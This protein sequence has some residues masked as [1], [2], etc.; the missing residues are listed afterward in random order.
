VDVAAALDAGALEELL[1]GA[2]AMVAERLPVDGIPEEGRIAA[3]RDAVIHN[4]TGHELA[5]LEMALA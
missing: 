5:T 1:V 2:M 4:A 3:V